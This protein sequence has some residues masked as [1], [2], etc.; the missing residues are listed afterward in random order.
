MIFEHA[1]NQW[2][3]WM[4]SVENQFTGV[5]RVDNVHQFVKTIQDGVNLQEDKVVQIGTD[6]T[7][8]LVTNKWIQYIFIDVLI[9]K[10]KIT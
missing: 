1:L 3:H 7:H 9:I 6:E 4:P 5:C 2:C 10:G 8:Y